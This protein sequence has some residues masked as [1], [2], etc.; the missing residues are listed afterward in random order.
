[1][2]RMD[3]SDGILFSDVRRVL[4]DRASFYSAS[5]TVKNIITERSLSL[6]LEKPDLLSHDDIERALFEI[7]HKVAL[8]EFQKSARSL[9]GE[10]TFY[11]DRLFR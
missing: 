8:E 9:H 6:A 5:E 2:M 10:Q 7:V 4:F 11:C 3:S 1:M